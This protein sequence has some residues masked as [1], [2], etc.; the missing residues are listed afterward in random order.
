MGF[1]APTTRAT[2]FFVTAAIWNAEHVD[3]FNTAVMHL[4]ARKTAD[5]SVTSSTTLQDDN[6]L[7]Y[8]IAANE[9]WYVQMAL[10]VV[11]GSDG[12]ANFKMGLTLPASATC[13]FSWVWGNTSGT[14]AMHRLR[15][16]TTVSLFG[17]AGGDLFSPPGVV[18]N[19]GTAGTVQLQWAQSTSNA[20]PVTVK[21]NSALWGVKLA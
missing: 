5:E 9:I 1:T 20:S 21:A 15:V 3:N 8:S 12:A 17:S 18:V 16:G 13:F 4:L 7:F 11:D 6:H 14:F 2:N 10:Y 19:A